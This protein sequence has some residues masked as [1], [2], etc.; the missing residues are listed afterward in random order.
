MLM[1]SN[2]CLEVA[3]FSILVGQKLL[4]WLDWRS[5]SLEKQR[6]VLLAITARYNIQS[7][8]GCIG[9]EVFI[10]YMPKYSLIV[11]SM[12]TVRKITSTENPRILSESRS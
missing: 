9:N 5:I 1:L 10:M 7:N 12:S 6:L 3:I 11:S 4:N 2:T 8:A